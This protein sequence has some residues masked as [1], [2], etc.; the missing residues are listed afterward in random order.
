MKGTGLSPR[1][2][3]FNFPS[4]IMGTLLAFLLTFAGGLLLGAANYF[5]SLSE[6]VL[7]MGGTLILFFSVICGGA[8]AGRRAAS[9]GL[10]HGAGTGLLFFILIWL[11][12]ANF[13]PTDLKMTSL[14]TKF[15]LLLVGGAV[16]GV[17]GIG[18]NKG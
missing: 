3:V 16:G 4:I 9:K 13:L 15:V 5:S 14:L 12:A 2:P 6:G 11:L 8:M 10:Y 1:T 7:P 18:I 17:L